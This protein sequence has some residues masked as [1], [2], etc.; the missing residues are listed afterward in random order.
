MIMWI[1]KHKFISLLVLSIVVYNTVWGINYYNFKTTKEGYKK[2]V[3]TYSKK[4]DNYS[5]SYYKPEY[6]Q[7]TG[8]YAISNYGDTLSII[9]WPPNIFEKDT[10][11]GLRIYD[12]NEKH[13]Y[14]FYV[15]KDLNY[16][17]NNILDDF[18]G[19]KAKKLLIVNNDELFRMLNV[20][21]AE[22]QEYNAKETFH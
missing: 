11:Y 7:F 14:M 18:D 9:L 21:E 12:N 22:V 3:K 19:E 17:P 1:K 10:S 20:L 6:L 13:G 4:I 5:V 16:L 8:N 15:D 2:N